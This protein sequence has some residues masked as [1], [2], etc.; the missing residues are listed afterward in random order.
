MYN[1]IGADEIP[2]APYRLPGVAPDRPGGFGSGSGAGKSGGKG[3]WLRG[4]RVVAAIV[5]VCA[6]AGGGA[7]AVVQATTSSPAQQQA[8][9]TQALSPQAGAQAGTSASAAGQ[10]SLLREV[11]TTTGHRR[12]ARLRLLGGMY[13]Q[14][15]FETKSGPRTLAFERGT[16]TSIVGNDVNVRAADGTTFTW[17]LTGTSV[18]RENGTKEPETTLAEGQAVFAGGPVTGGSRDARLIV[19]RKAGTPTQTSGAA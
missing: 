1:G 2:T 11:L 9:N 14:F 17:V 10:A 12:L 18:V 3:G 5:A 6:A 15:T 13:G 7:F 16:I 8:A 19:I 4:K